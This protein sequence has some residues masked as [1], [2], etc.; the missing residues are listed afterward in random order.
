MCHRCLPGREAGF[1]FFLK[2]AVGA[3]AQALAMG[4]CRGAPREVD[5]TAKMAAPWGKPVSE[6]TENAEQAEEEGVKKLQETAEG[7]PRS[8]EVLHGRAHTA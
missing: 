3:G 2:V 4:G 1:W 7:T 5:P 6:M 8:E